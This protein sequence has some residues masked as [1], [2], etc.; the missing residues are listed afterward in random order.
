MN[1]AP[2]IVWEPSPERIASATITRYREWLNETRGLALER[3]RRALAVVGRRARGVLGLDLGVLR[4]R[5]ERAVRA[6]ARERARC[7]APS[8]SQVRGSATPST[9]SATATTTTSRSA[10]PRSC[11]RSATGRGASCGRTPAP[12]PQRCAKRAS[13]QATASPPTSRTSPRRSPP[14][15][16]ARASARSGRAAR[17]SSAS[18]ASSTASRRSSRRCCSTVDGYRYGGKDFDRSDDDRGARARAADGRVGRS[19]S[20]TWPAATGSCPPPSSSSRSCRSTTRSGCSTA[21]ARP[22]CRRRS[23]TA[24]AGSCS[25]TSRSSASTST[26]APATA[27]SGSRRPAG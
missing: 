2:P 16:A 8:G 15:S 10:T 6:R 18:A 1:H 12:S 9:S 21:P 4:R 23:S 3:L 5:G 24:R 17:R 14:S 20:R 22:A 26:R 19:S 27:S 7:P 11:V 25:S 13:W